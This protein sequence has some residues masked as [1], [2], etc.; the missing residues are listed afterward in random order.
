MSP[1][2]YWTM[3]YQV[4]TMIP[5]VLVYYPE[6]TI[7]QLPRL[8]YIVKYVN[9]GLSKCCVLVNNCSL[10]AHF[11]YSISPLTRAPADHGISRRI[12]SSCVCY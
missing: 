9:R 7:N 5:R 11:T 3:L 4:L 1:L 10:I 6:A 2:M 12:W 8:G